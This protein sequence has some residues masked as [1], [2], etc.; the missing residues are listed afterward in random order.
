MLT[1]AHTNYVNRHAG[2]EDNLLPDQDASVDLPP[3]NVVRRYPMDPS[4]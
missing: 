2:K 3:L 1:A 4:I